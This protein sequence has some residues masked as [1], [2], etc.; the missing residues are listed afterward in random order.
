[1]NARRAFMEFICIM[2]VL[3]SGMAIAVFILEVI[4]AQYR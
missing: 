4:Y 3:Y 2:V 1:M